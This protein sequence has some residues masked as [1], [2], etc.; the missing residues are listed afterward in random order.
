MAR[1]EHRSSAAEISHLSPK[2]GFAWAGGVWFG[3]AC[4]FL[5]YWYTCRRSKPGASVHCPEYAELIPNFRYLPLEFMACVRANR[6]LKG[7]RLR[8]RGGCLWGGCRGG[9]SDLSWRA[10][11]RSLYRRRSSSPLPSRS[12]LIGS[13]PGDLE[14]CS[15]R[16]LGVASSK[17]SDDSIL[18]CVLRGRLSLSK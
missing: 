7:L 10:S 18:D 6:L 1:E 15:R 14:L 9:W 8:S 17:K 2:D 4:F 5:S 12:S 3:G 11:S 16:S 13:R